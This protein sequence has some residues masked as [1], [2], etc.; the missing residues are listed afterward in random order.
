[1]SITEH[2]YTPAYVVTSEAE[3]SK[4]PADVQ[5]ALVAA[6]KESQDYVYKTAAKLETDLLTQLK[7]GGIAVNDADKDAFIAASKPIYDEFASTVEN[8]AQL[9]AD[10]Q[11]LAK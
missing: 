4:L 5:E 2:V 11:A 6:A 8:G 3:F 9:I 1:M 7:A 10:V